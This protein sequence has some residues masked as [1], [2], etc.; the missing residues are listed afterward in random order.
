MKFLRKWNCWGL[1]TLFLLPLAGAKAANP[2]EL[3]QFFAE[4][5]TM[6]G[7]F[8]QTLI[9][10]RGKITQ[11]VSGRFW[12]E[13]PGRFRWDYQQPYEQLIVANGTKVWIYDADLEQVTVKDQMQ[14]MGSAPAQLLSQPDSLDKNFNVTALGTSDGLTWYELTPKDTETGFDAVKMAFSQGGL[15][16]MELADTLG[17]TTILRF[18]EIER[19]Q[20]ID[21]GLFAFSP[22]KGVDVITD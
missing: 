14:A 4:F 17:Q 6:S 5:K 15:K 18:T 12:L 20:A 21:P 22:P 10:G 11:G 8:S 16:A 7:A 9:D 2:D 1:L 13:R 3:T 19:N